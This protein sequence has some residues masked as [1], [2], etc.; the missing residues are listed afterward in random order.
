MTLEYISSSSRSAFIRHETANHQAPYLYLG[1]AN[2]RFFPL[3]TKP[4]DSGGGLS[5]NGIVLAGDAARELAADEESESLSV[6]VF[7]TT[8]PLP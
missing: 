8:V 4:R 5:R 6:S 1:P 3:R 2:F 7:P